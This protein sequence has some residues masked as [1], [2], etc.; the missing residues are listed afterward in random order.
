M[1]LCL[2]K[3]TTLILVKNY[4][5]QLENMT[6][7]QKCS[8][9]KSIE[10]GISVITSPFKNIEFTAMYPSEEILTLTRPPAVLPTPTNTM[11]IVCRENTNLAVSQ[12]LLLTTKVTFLNKIILNNT[13]Q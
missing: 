2:F 6:S 7:K 4:H 3:H 12:T 1:N 8:L 13:P 10:L 11:T 9:P 5:F